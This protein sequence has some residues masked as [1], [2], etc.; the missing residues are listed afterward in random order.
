MKKLAIALLSVSAIL[1][2]A[3]SDQS[4]N[5]K[6]DPSNSQYTNSYNSKIATPKAIDQ[7]LKDERTP[8]LGDHNADKAV[9]I[10]YYKTSI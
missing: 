6:I 7:L 5:N 4:S 3:F 2:N 1:I 8:T 9:I 10:F